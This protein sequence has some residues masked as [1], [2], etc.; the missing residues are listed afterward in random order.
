MLVW[1]KNEPKFAWGGASPLLYAGEGGSGARKPA[2]PTWQRWASVL[3]AV[4]QNWAPEASALGRPVYGP[5]GPG[6]APLG[7]RLRQW[8]PFLLGFLPRLV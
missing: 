6:L 1:K 7:P 3:G 8:P 2:K 5:A 4:R